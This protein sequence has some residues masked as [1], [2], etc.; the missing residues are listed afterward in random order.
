MAPLRRRDTTSPA[1]GSLTPGFPHALALLSGLFYEPNGRDFKV[2]LV[3]GKKTK[4]KHPPP[5]PATHAHKTP[6]SLSEEAERAVSRGCVGLRSGMDGA[7]LRTEPVEDS[8]KGWG[9]RRRGG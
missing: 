6:R 3:E 5:P 2:S 9:P 8:G 1:A 4:Q 7:R